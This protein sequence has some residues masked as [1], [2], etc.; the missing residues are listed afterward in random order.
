MNR[1]IIPI[2]SLALLAYVRP[3]AGQ[4]A[5]FTYQGQALDNGTNFTGTGLF[6]FA[7]VTGTN[8]QFQTWWS[9]DGTS[10]NGSQPTAAVS[11]TVTGGL[12]TLVLG[13]TNLSNMT[14]VPAGLFTE[15]GLQL[16]IWF[17]D[18]VNGFAA[19]NPPQNLTAT[20]Y[21][22]FASLANGLVGLSVQPN[23][24]GA[25]NL[26]GGS[27]ANF[28]GVTVVGATIAG[29]GATNFNGLDKSNSVTAN[30]GTVSGGVGN[31][32]SGNGAFVG[33]GG[34]DGTNVAGN[35]AEGNA[36]VV[37]GGVGNVASGV[38]STVGGGASNSAAFFWATVGGGHLNQAEDRYSTVAGGQENIA[39]GAGAYVGG[40]GFDGANSN[41]NQASG[42]ASVVGGGVGNTAG[43]NS[44]TVG[45][46]AQNNATASASTVAGGSD[47]TATA[48][49]CTVGG[50]FNNH[51]TN[52]YATVPGGF[53]NLAGGAYSFAAGD[54]AQATNEGA[55]VWADSQNAAFGSTTSNQVSFRCLGG[56]L[57]TSGS[58]GSNQT[59]SWTPGSA[60]WSFSSD[61]N[62]KDRFETVKSALVLERVLQLP[63]VEWSYK[64]YTQR[65]IGA[66]AQDF[67]TLFP[68]NPDDKSLNDADL[69][70]VELA[71]IQG[72]NQKA[73]SGI[74]KAETQ[75]E[76]LKT[77]NAELKKRLERLEQLVAARADSR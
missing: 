70:G 60:S 52:N 13:N 36:S 11:V 48:Q 26:I 58:G 38:Y 39:G 27:S 61:R 46:G 63:I 16:Q 53:E 77:E 54:Q 42:N 59:V 23:T 49:Q 32:A 18:G 43:G 29:G 31:T 34:F 28:I 47:N 45:G 71:A 37:G 17:S 19:L 35:S 6:K 3:A 4:S 40:G 51:A 21:A 64:G 9:N 41:G 30:F 22:S 72:L 68:L 66:M 2:L 24:N 10:T 1:N 5:D 25:P 15:P 57:F 44:S 50:G 73:E 75:I 65:H 33:G 69:H 20:P 55:F 14:T 74:Q 7:L 8:G 62:L 76:Q 12:F 56:V 67:H